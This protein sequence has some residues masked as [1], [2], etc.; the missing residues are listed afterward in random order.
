MLTLLSLETGLGLLRTTHFD[1]NLIAYAHGL[2]RT[3]NYYYSYPPLPD[4]LLLLLPFRL[5]PPPVPFTNASLVQL[6]MDTALFEHV[7]TDHLVTYI[8]LVEE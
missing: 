1:Q 2:V 5:F 7:C 3:K 8:N 6:H 4:W